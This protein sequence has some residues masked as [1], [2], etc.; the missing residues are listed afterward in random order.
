MRA[1]S[2]GL[3]VELI[4]RRAGRHVMIGGPVQGAL[5]LDSKEIMMGE[6]EIWTGLPAC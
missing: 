6:S 5:A 4:F 3:G 1:I 2:E